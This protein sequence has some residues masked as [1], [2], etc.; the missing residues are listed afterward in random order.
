MRRCTDGFSLIE[1]V[2]VIAIMAILAGAAAPLLV[3]AV[4]QQRITTT[5]ANLQTAWQ[6]AFGMPGSRVQNMRADFGFDPQVGLVDLGV[7]MDPKAAPGALPLVYGHYGTVPFNY[8]WNGPYWNGSV[9]TNAAGFSVPVDGWGRPI[10]LLHTAGSTAWQMVSFGPD[11]VPGNPD[12]L[13]YPSQRVNLGLAYTGIVYFNINNQRP[14]GAD[15][16]AGWSYQCEDRSSS[17]LNAS[18]TKMP[19]LTAGSAVTPA[20]TFNVLP[21]PVYINVTINGYTAGL[22]SYNPTNF[23]EIIDVLP[24]QTQVVNITL[25]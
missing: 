25:N 7:M 16:P 9:R 24:G 17:L 3:K 12:N 22:V 1:A 23:S 14:A 15:V 13:Y 11:G 10:Q 19:I 4:D 5:Q 21:G 6:A 8:G 2:V 20:P 18:A